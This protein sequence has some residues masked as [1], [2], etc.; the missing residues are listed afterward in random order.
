MD[1]FID[2]MHDFYGAG[3]VYPIGITTIEVI[4]AT[5]KRLEQ[6]P[7]IEFSGDSLD[8]EKVRDVI[9]DMRGE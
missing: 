3:G 4:I 7:D 2:Y 6:H 8:R 5:G 1:K 9:L